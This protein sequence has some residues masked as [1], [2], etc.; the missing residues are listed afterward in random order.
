MVSS[1]RAHL[2]A[3]ICILA[4]AFSANAL[5]AEKPELAQADSKP[6][7]VPASFVAPQEVPAAKAQTPPADDR[8]PQVRLV[9]IKTDVAKRYRAIV[10]PL[11]IPPF[12]QWRQWFR[13]HENAVHC[14]LEWCDE[15]GN[16]WHGEL[17]STH[18]DEN[19]EQYRV[20]FGE[21]PGTAYDAYGI[22]IMPGRV[23]R[24]FD[25]EGRPLVITLDEEVPCDYRDVRRHICQYAAKDKRPGEEGT[26][27]RGKTN[28]GLGGPAY[29]PSQNSNT[30]VKYILRACGVN[31][32]A[33]E[34]AVGWDS[35]P[36]FPYSS[37]ADA[38]ETESP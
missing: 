19:A 13:D 35:E 14:A 28:V 34:L 21:F 26:G 6:V 36:H 17:R 11:P 27:G 32:K 38:P 4:G 2:T 37:N 12:T 1:R 31:R 10:P 9:A 29:K 7:G 18:F 23:K 15:E 33:P 5:E 3:I 30:M 24:D 22:Y 25:K 8:R 20:G 16:W